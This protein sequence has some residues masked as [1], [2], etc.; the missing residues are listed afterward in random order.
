LARLAPFN[1]NYRYTGAELSHLLVDARPKVLVYHARLAGRVDEIRTTLADDV[2]LVQVGDHS[3]EPLVDG[4]VEYERLL[5]ESSA[6]TPDTEPSA[7]DLHIVFTGGTTGLPKGVLW[8]IGD[9]IAGPLQLARRDGTE[10]ESVDEVV[11][12]AT[13]RNVRTLAAPPFMHGA[14][15][16]VAMTTVTS[17]GTL[18]IQDTNDR[19]LAEEV[20]G[21][22][23]RERVAVLSLV[24]DGMG[25]PFADAVETGK[26]D[27]SSLKFLNN[28]A[29][30]MSDDTKRRLQQRIQG[31]IILDGLGSSEGGNLGARAEGDTFTLDAGGVLLS[32]DMSRELRPGDD[33]VGWLCTRT[34]HARGYL[35]DRSKTEAT[36]IDHHGASL[37]ISGDRARYRPDGTIELLGRDSMTINSGGEKIFVEEVE[38]ALRRIPGVVDALVV[39]RPH[40]RWGSEVV[41]VIEVEPGSCASDDELR[42]AA[43]RDLA[44]YKLPR[45]FIRVPKVLRAANGKA[46]YA[47]ARTV[48][49]ERAG[50]G[51]SNEQ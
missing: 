36:F 21:L 24:G 38:V 3:G 9:V 16:W 4:A 47:W 43:A 30:P 34:R 41:A 33:E 39:G 40:E 2:L 42:D 31:L 51:A 11:A 48:A 13:K 28:G 29:A 25:K 14:G 45:E 23:A 50:A 5:A 32:E 17:G 27:L 6:A 15:L 18:V 1:L 26:Y 46:D 22:C 19:F 49:V 12:V 44:R 8:R 7:D 35:H 10:F 37:V 20:A